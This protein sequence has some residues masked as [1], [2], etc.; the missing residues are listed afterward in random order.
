MTKYKV[1]D[2]ISAEIYGISVEDDG[3]IFYKIRGLPSTYNADYIDKYWVVVRRRKEVVSR[4]KYAIGQKIGDKIIARKEW[5]ANRWF[6]TLEEKKEEVMSEKEV[7]VLE[8][9]EETEI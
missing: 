2:I 1:G 6:Y 4:P 5:F 3:S 8:R 9:N 7:E